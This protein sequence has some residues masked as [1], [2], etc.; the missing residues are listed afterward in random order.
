MR[1]QSELTGMWSNITDEDIARANADVDLGMGEMGGATGGGMELP[2]LGSLSGPLAGEG[3]PAP[4]LTPGSLA[5]LVKD[6]DW[7]E[8]KHPRGGDPENSGRFSKIVGSG[9]QKGL[10]KKDEPAKLESGSGEHGESG[11]PAGFVPAKTIKEADEYAR[12]AFDVQA[13]Y[14]GV[15]LEVANEWNK[16]LTVAF[17]RFPELRNQFGFVGEAHERNKLYKEAAAAY[18]QSEYAGRF[19]E[20]GIKRQINKE[21]RKQAISP[22]EAA[23]SWSSKYDWDKPFRGVTINR[24]RAKTHK[25]LIEDLEYALEKKSIPEGCAT[26][27]YLLDHEVGHQLE[28][29]LDIGEQPNIQQLF[30]SRTEAQLTDDLSSYVWDNNNRNRYS[31][32]IA[33]GW[34]EYLNNPNPRPM[35]MEIGKTIERLYDEWKKKN[36]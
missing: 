34:A 3:T 19:S 12:N 10:P 6:A 20:G 5:H 11:A 9:G 7:D 28:N 27:R 4:A 13:S 36:S 31:E 22:K 2:G 14:K 23:I 8:S 1:Q 25:A 16:W 17:E 35:A 21:M 15:D 30:D 26:V 32:M 33:E 18:F 24:D 29:M